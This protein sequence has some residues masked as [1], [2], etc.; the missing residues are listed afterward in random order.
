[1]QTEQE[2]IDE[3]MDEFDFVKV[4]KV[5]EALD[6]GW[7]MEGVPYIG[8]M[9]KVVR[10]LFK[11]AMA[12]GEN[13]L[14]YIISTGGFHITRTLFPGDPKRYYSLKFVVTEQNNY[15]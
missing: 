5:M 8:D 11:T 3:I 14:S 9:R 7:G 1:M 15:E 6:W 10:N 2:D 12:H 4:H 13:E